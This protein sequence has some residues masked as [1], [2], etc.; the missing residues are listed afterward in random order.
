VEATSQCGSPCWNDR[1]EQ[2]L[3]V[4]GGGRHIAVRTSVR[5]G[6]GNGGRGACRSTSDAVACTDCQL[7]AGVVSDK[8]LTAPNLLIA[9]SVAISLKILFVILRNKGNPMNVLLKTKNN[10]E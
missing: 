2:L 6:I 5:R 9:K 1:S 3:R 10:Y 8:N 4:V 7:H